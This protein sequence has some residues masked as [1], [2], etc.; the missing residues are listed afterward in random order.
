MVY[1]YQDSAHVLHVQE[2]R[3]FVAVAANMQE[4]K[5]DSSILILVLC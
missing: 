4:P 3:A 2:V 5:L 1:P